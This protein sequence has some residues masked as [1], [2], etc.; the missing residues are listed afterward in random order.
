MTLAAGFLAAVKRNTGMTFDVSQIQQPTVEKYAY[1]YLDF[2]DMV[3][4]NSVAFMR[5]SN[6]FVKNLF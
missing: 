2:G 5:N 1:K 4:D 6:Y 3:Y